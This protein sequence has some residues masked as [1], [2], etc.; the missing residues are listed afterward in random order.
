M[1]LRVLLPFAL[2]GFAVSIP[3]VQNGDTLDSEC[4]T[5]ISDEEMLTVEKM[6]KDRKSSLDRSSVSATA[7]ID[8]YFNVIYED[9]SM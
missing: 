7:T 6:F 3:S 2:V 8:V 9:Q 4:D 1:L 5:Y